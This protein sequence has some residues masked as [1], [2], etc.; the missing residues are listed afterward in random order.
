MIASS[1][2]FGGALWS[3]FG[4]FWDG[5]GHKKPFNLGQVGA[6]APLGCALRHGTK[7]P[8]ADQRDLVVGIVPVHDVPPAQG[9][10]AA[11]RCGSEG[12]QAFRGLGL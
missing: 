2:D 10:N 5:D 4:P 7:P 9:A 3:D 11:G 6:T 12:G 8:R 1:T